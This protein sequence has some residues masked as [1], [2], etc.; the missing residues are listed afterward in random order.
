MLSSPRTMEG[1]QM[2][3]FPLK[4]WFDGGQGGLMADW[5]VSSV[6]V[7]FRWDANG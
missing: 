1:W 4:R 3:L 5:I 6:K 2:V 7:Y